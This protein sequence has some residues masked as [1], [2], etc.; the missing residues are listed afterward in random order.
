M[1][2]TQNSVKQIK[3]DL[4]FELIRD[5]RL[6]SHKIRTNLV[7]QML[8]HCETISSGSLFAPS[9]SLQSYIAL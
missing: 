1:S 3:S 8:N 6:L 2:V 7:Y 9:L 5:T 4:Y